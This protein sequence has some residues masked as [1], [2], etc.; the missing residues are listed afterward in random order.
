M[1][2]AYIR[3]NYGLDFVKRGMRVKY[4]GKFGTITSCT[5]L[6]IIRLDCLDKNK[7][8]RVHPNDEDL[9]YIK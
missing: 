2:V 8:I 3:G 1:G 4:K 9:E 7:R 6:I 5:H